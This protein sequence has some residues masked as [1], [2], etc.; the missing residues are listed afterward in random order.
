MA[1]DNKIF[2][3]DQI[4]PLI[5]DIRGHKVILD[6]D[7]AALY[8][9]PTK[10]LNQ[11]VKRYREHFPPDAVFRLTQDEV[12]YLRPHR[13]ARFRA[14]RY[15][16]YAFTEPG[17]IKAAVNLSSSLALEMML[18][19]ARAFEKQ[20]QLA[21]AQKEL[22]ARLEQLEK[23]VTDHDDSIGQLIAAVRELISRN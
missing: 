4:E 3:I 8:G 9:V 20:R 15:P 17:I 6:R 19:I 18:L 14:I 2:L 13:K 7:L 5:A 1:N 11:T 22:A 16:P 21:Q 12:G 10:M 23:K